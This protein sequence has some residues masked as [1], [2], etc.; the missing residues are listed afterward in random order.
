[1]RNEPRIEPKPVAQSFAFQKLC[2]FSYAWVQA[3][4]LE[5]NSA[6]PA[7][8]ARRLSDRLKREGTHGEEKRNELL[9]TGGTP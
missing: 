4:Q 8:K 2:G 6:L 7:L 3:A 5:G 9:E 1:M